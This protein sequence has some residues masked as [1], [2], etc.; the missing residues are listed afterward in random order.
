MNQIMPTEGAPE[1]K[2]LNLEEAQED[3]NMLASYLENGGKP[4]AGD[5]NKALYQLEMLEEAVNEG[6]IESMDKALRAFTAGASIVTDR[7]PRLLLA[8]ALNVMPY[9]KKFKENTRKLLGGGI[10]EQLKNIPKDYE[11]R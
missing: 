8:A 5:Y 11:K 3:A 1:H 4:T 2:K 6:P 10:I 9:P 7:I